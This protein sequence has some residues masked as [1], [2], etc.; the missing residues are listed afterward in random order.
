MNDDDDLFRPPNDDAYIKQEVR[1]G[2]P[3]D[4]VAEK[5]RRTLES[6]HDALRR[7]DPD[8]PRGCQLRSAFHTALI[9]HLALN[10][11]L[12][13]VNDT[14]AEDRLLQMSHEQFGDW[15]DRVAQGGSVSG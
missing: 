14:G 15:L 3:L 8:P 4:Y 7:P 5:T 1:S 13:L 11:M 9:A 12:A 10:N 2:P 6:L